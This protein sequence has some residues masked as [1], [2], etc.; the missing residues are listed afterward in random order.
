[1]TDMLIKEAMH[2]PALYE[3]SP[4]LFWSDPYISSQLLKAHLD[5]SDPLASRS[6]SFIAKSV[7]WIAS[8]MPDGGGKRILD[9]GCGPGLYASRLAALGYLVT[10]IDVSPASICFAR[11]QADRASLAIE[12]QQRDYLLDDLGGPYDMALLAYCDY[13]ALS[14]EERAS[15]L[16]K[17]YE[18]LRVGGLM[19]FD[20]FSMERYTTARDSTRWEVTE[21]GG[22]WR[23]E[24][25]LCLERH[26]LYPPN[27]LLDRYTVSTKEEVKSYNVWTT[28]FDRES[29]RREVE[30]AGFRVLQ[31][32]ADLTG[33]PYDDK[34][35][36]IAMAL[37]RASWG[38]LDNGA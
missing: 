1:M 32:A 8:L 12:Y 4:E 35:E 34:G 21:R 11:E 25:N 36:T 24:P 18:S 6:P 20:V 27:A 22:L 23:Q 14:I 17:A 29:L 5:E 33:A 3:R 28:C 9:L 31:Y 7:D 26:A 16:S 37:E 15:L 38:H 10:G 19:V 2:Q 30:R 13:G